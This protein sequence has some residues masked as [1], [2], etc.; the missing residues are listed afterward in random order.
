MKADGDSVPAF[1][2]WL[3]V[4]AVEGAAVLS[5]LTIGPFLLLLALILSGLLLWRVDFG[6]GMAGM[7]SGAALPVAYVAWLNRGGPGPVCSSYADGGQTCTDAWSPWPFVGV[8]V[9]LLVA[10]LVVF[11]RNRG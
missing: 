6:W 5:I 4:G 9:A 3:V 10:G 2:G 7:I 1:V 11:A 8:A